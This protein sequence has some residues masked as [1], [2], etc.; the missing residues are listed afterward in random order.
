MQKARVKI[1]VDFGIFKFR[2]LF[3]YSGKQK[4]VKLPLFVKPFLPSY[5][6]DH[7]LATSVARPWIDEG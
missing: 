1:S 2:A 4:Q 7:G 3:E 6:I 5:P